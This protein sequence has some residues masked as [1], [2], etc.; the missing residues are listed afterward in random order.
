MSILKSL[1]K[2]ANELDAAGLFQEA[3][4][5]DAVIT[6]LAGQLPSELQVKYDEL[7]AQYKVVGVGTSKVIGNLGLSRSTAL[8][9]AKADC[10][11]K[12][13][14]AGKKSSGM[15]SQVYMKVH[16]G[17]CYVFAADKGAE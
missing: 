8:E 7:V 5:L 3:S 17:V 16:D 6:K 12:L 13:K 2:I 4:A 11:E 1:V 9:K 14:S 15:I 10:A